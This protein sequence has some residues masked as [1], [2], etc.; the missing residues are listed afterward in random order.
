[1]LVFKHKITVI[2]A[3]FVFP[4][5]CMSCFRNWI[6]T[7]KELKGHYQNN[8]HK[9]T[10]ITIEKDSFKLHLA[11]FGSSF[12][13]PVIF[14]HGA[15]GSWDGYLNLL[16]DTL[17]QNDFHLISVD[18]P[19]YGK[20]IKD[21][22]KKIY[23]L[24]EQAKSI[25][26]SL[27]INHSPKRAILVGRSYGVPVAVKLAAMYPD[28]IA[29]CILISPA[30]DPS[31]EKFWWFS[32]FGKIFLVRWFLPA[33]MNTATDEKFS[34]VAE[35]RKLLPDWQKINANISVMMG[36]KDWIIDSSNFQFAKKMLIGKKAK[37]IHI[38]D[39]GHLISK[40]RPDL[41]IKEI[42]SEN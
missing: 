3:F 42:Y 26:L 34:H 13:Q 1:M 6:M 23:T 9:P 32:N 18:R 30:I 5:L 28:K 38:P 35:L 10:Y 31:S 7:E 11:S 15:P 17:L 27:S 33:R 41:V 2:I 4:I 25:I 39:S 19:G 40:T 14:I 16:D 24:E 37:F 21:S 36:G 8:K 12:S 29:K 22:K 20:S